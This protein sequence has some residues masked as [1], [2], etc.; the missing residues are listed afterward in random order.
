MD[1]GIAKIASSNL[2][3]T[4][5]FLGTPNYMSPEQ[6]SGAAGGRPQRHLLARRRSLRAADQPQAVPGRQ[7]HGD[8]L[9]DRPRGLHASG[10]PVAGRAAGVQRDRRASDGQG[11]LE[12]LPARQGPRARAVPVEGPPRGAARAPGPR[13]DGLGGGE[14]A[15]AQAGESRGS[16]AAQGS[17]AGAT[18]TAVPPM[19][20]ALAAVSPPAMPPRG[21]RRHGFEPTPTPNPIERHRRPAGARSAAIPSDRGACTSLPAAVESLL[22]ASSRERGAAAAAAAASSRLRRCRPLAVSSERRTGRRSPRRRS[23]RPTSGASPRRSGACSRSSVSLRSVAGAMAAR[24]TV[25]PGSR[26]REGES[27]PQAG[28]GGRQEALRRRQVRPEPGVVASGAR[29]QPRQP[30]G[31]PVRPDGR[32]RASGRAE[33]QAKERAG[34]RRVAAARAALSES[35]YEEAVRKAEEALALDAGNAEAQERQGRGRRQDRRGPGAARPPRARR[36]REDK[37]VA[38]AKR[39]S[40][41]AAVRRGPSTPSGPAA[42]APLRCTGPATL[43]LVFDSPISEGSVMIDVND[44]KPLQK[45]FT[46]KKSGTLKR[47]RQRRP[48][49]RARDREGVALRPERAPRR[50]S[51]PRPGSLRAERRGRC[52]STTP[53]AS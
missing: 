8:L 18:T 4:G 31:A 44:E 28:P 5:Q 53:A 36:G 38:S 23:I 25:L 52:S 32:E 27:G 26:P 34:G 41:P 47:A 13:L 37:K 6:V 40:D 33:E 3:T 46:F 17:P 14:H 11:S 7:P 35:R 50:P 9:Q 2:T 48:C 1:F 10:R 39:R 21:H 49:R 43:R 19:R 22:G 45:P 20:P 29:P 42:P 24:P 30:A 16:L 15:D 12:P 51:P